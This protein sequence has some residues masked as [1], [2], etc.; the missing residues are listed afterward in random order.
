LRFR[1]LFA[2]QFTLGMLK[3]RGVARGRRIRRVEALDQGPRGIAALAQLG[4]MLAKGG[5]SPTPRR[6]GLAAHVIAILPDAQQFEVKDLISPSTRLLMFG[7]KGGV[8]KTTCAAAVALRA[9]R[10]APARRVLLLSA[11][12]AHSPGDVLGSTLSNHERR[13]SPE[14]RNLWVRELNA[15][16]SF[17]EIRDRIADGIEQLFRRVRGRA[18]KRRGESRPTGHARPD[19][20]CAARDR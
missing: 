14:H 3:D 19:R 18:R 10:E 11:D 1:C 20:A 4:T 2:T 13:I 7:G 17:A 9:A 8:G 16:E 6:R 5:A 12:P 15:A